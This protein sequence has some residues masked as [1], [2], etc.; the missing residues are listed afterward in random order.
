MDS[1][2]QKLFKTSKDGYLYVGDIENG[3]FVTHMEHLSCFLPGTMA[4]A[5][6]GAKDEAS[7]KWYLENAE[8]AR[9]PPPQHTHAFIRTLPSLLPPRYC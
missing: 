7:S 5:S 2:K 8:G 6:Q 9:A 3:R 1:A 4:M